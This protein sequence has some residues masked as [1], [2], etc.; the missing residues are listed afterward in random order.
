MRSQR[1]TL[2]TAALLAGAVALTACAEAAGAGWPMRK[3]GDLLAVQTPHYLLHTDHDADVAQLV[4]AQQEAL[5]RE[6]YDRMGKIKPTKLT[7]RFKI[8]VFQGMGRYLKELGPAA[9]GSQGLYNHDK[10]MLAAWGPPEYLE[11]VLET[12]RHEGTHQFVMHFIGPETPIWLNE[13]LA[14]FYQH[15]RFKKGRLELGEVPPK[16]I[17]RLKDAIKKHQ[18]IHLGRMLRM[19]HMEWL[20]AVN[21]GGSHAGLQY[22]QAW[23]MVHFLAFANHRRYRGPFTQFIYFISR[24]RSPYRAWEKTFGT[25]FAAFEERWTEYIK[26]LD[27][28]ENLPCRDRLEVLALLTLRYHKEHPEAFKD[29]AALRKALSDGTFGKWSQHS[30]AGLLFKHDDPKGINLLFRCPADDRRK[31]QT[32]YELVPGKDGGPPVIRCPHHVGYVLETKYRDDS[33]PGEP[34]VQ[35]VTRPHLEKAGR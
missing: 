19:S 34:R 29:I 32:S 3:E 10:D 2:T 25:N 1:L 17:L 7:G 27:A 6:L 35:I 14:V 26:S 18:F 21:M 24:G 30:T 28:I 5:F 33:R 23:A 13:G 4:A 22:D 15:S 11:V 12:L 31:P 9:M 16:R 20:T 8:K